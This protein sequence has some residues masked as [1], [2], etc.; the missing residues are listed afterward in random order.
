MFTMS[1]QNDKRVV[2]VAKIISDVELAD[3]VALDLEFSGLFLSP[4]RERRGLSMEEYF[5]KCVESIPQFLPLQ[6]GLCCARWRRDDAIWELRTHELYL[7]PQTRRIFSA[8][9]QSLKF[10]RAHGFDFNAF[11]EKGLACCRL[12]PPPEAIASNSEKKNNRSSRG[13]LPH[14]SQ[15]FDALR[16]AAVPLVVHNGLL[17]LLHLH[18]KFLGDLPLTY[19]AFGS[20]WL[21]HFPL[22]FDTRHLA[23]EGRHVIDHFGGLSL[24][25]LHRSLTHGASCSKPPGQFDRL[26]P[27]LPGASPHGSAGKDAMLTAE[28]FIMEVELWLRADASVTIISVPKTSQDPPKR[29][30]VSENS[31]LAVNV[32]PADG[33]IE[34]TEPTS[35]TTIDIARGGESEPKDKLEKDLQHLGWQ[36]LHKRATESGVSI[37]RPGTK[38]RRSTAEIRKALVARAVEGGD[39]T[40][41]NSPA[42]LS[43]HEACKRFHNRVAIVGS[44]RGSL[45]LGVAADGGLVV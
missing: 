3:F 30:R 40:L 8:D 15:V 26:G 16:S 6:L 18:D 35:A 11:L 45:L 14:G 13:Q 38:E 36:E 25:E 41:F 42:L 20:S 39:I 37:V 29:R 34:G 24:E 31:S 22:L 33:I 1:G 28:V 12:P 21:A 5:T 2:A 17:D 9:M 23:Q 32:A 10:L 27:V 7:W 4:E 19:D 43:T 44:S